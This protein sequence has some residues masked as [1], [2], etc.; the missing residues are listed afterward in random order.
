MVDGIGDF[1][2]CEGCTNKKIQNRNLRLDEKAEIGLIIRRG[3]L[4]ILLPILASSKMDTLPSRK[5][6]SQSTTV[7]YGSAVSLNFL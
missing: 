2:V 5:R 3:L 4:W 1:P 7:E 6:P